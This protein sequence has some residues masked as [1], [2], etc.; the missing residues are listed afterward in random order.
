MGEGWVVRFVE[1]RGGEKSSA[2]RCDGAISRP[3][4]QSGRRCF[5]HRGRAAPASPPP[6][7][8][9]RGRGE[10]G[11]TVI[12]LPDAAVTEALGERIAPLLRRHDVVALF[13]DL[14][15]GKTTLV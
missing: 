10:S 12:A 13:G 4:W 9:H 15:A 7:L 6:G 11:A 5:R 3:A 1:G 8:P 14:G 2:S